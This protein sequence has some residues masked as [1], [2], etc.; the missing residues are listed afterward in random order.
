M[1][2]LT[3]FTR[4]S[5]AIKM[6]FSGEYAQSLFAQPAVEEKDK[7]EPTPAVEIKETSTDSALQLL[8]LLQK[9]GRLVDFI[10]EDVNAF[11]DE[12]V[13]SAARVVHQGVKKCLSDHVT[14]EAI[15]QAME[16]EST[17]IPQDFNRN[18]IRLTGNIAS[19]GPFNGVLV[20]KGWKATS[21][22]LPSVVDGT[23]LSVIMPAEVEL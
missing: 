8:A 20:H 3:F 17:Q 5:M 13:A 18:E 7:E 19:N 15:S 14:F 4:L 21:V 6:I 1:E 11:S 10:N 9:E 2:Q 23:D 16:G 22:N 12:Q